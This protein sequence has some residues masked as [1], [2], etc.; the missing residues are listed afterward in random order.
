LVYNSNNPAV[1]DPS[2]PQV[3]S[4][5]PELPRIGI[6]AGI[7]WGAALVSGYFLRSLTLPY[8]VVW[9]FLAAGISWAL[10]YLRHYAG[11]SEPLAPEFD[12]WLPAVERMLAGKDPGRWPGNPDRPTLERLT[13]ITEK[14]A[15]LRKCEEKASTAAAKLKAAHEK[16]DEIFQMISQLATSIEQI[17]N[18]A[19][20]QSETAVDISNVSINLSDSF[21]LIT[22]FVVNAEK[23]SK[24][25][26]ATASARSSA[27][28][29][30]IDLLLKI[31][32]ALS[33][34]L[35]I[36]RGME[37]NSSEI[38]QFIGAIRRIAK[39]T[40]LLALNAAIEAARAGEHGRGFAVVADEVKKLAEQSTSSAKDVTSIIEIVRDQTQQAISISQKNEDTVM[41][42]QQVADASTQAFSGLVE[43]IGE[44][45]TLF[46]QINELTFIQNMGIENVKK[47]TQEISAASEE[48]A[49]TVQEINAVC[50]ELKSA[51]EHFK[52]ILS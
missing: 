32:Q 6:A 19:T 12:S 33:T 44:F 26:M 38:E 46:S 21:E 35:E 24:A 31:R 47:R 16:V 10:E 4:W 49:S 45:A 18:A 41:H 27:A 37:K 42:A 30:A 23:K 36:I 50:Q 11:V 25:A 34:Y 43:T 17:S 8:A 39:Q 20:D 14:L 51:M 15:Q 1:P 40:N 9:L 7:I 22:D 13:K 2:Q 28:K 52:Q 48:Y 5:R 29:E 3:L